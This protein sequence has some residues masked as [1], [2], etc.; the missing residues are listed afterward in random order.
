MS[1][2]T[3]DKPAGFDG[4]NKTESGLVEEE[5]EP[6]S[7]R[8]TLMSRYGKKATLIVVFLLITAYYIASMIITPDD[9][10]VRSVLYFIIAFKILFEFIPVSV[11]TKPVV[12]VLG[13]IP[14]PQIP[15]VIKLGVGIA[16]IILSVLLVT[17]LSPQTDHGDLT[18]RCQSLLG[19]CS[20][21]ILMFITSRN[22]KMINWQTVF[23]G[24]FFQLVLGLFVI[25]TTIGSDLFSWLSGRCA[26]FIGFAEQGTAFVFYDFPNQERLRNGVDRVGISFALMVLPGILFFASFIQILY[27]LG[28]MQWVIG[29]FARFF[30]WGMDTSGS[31]SVVAAAS[32][33]VGMGESALLVKP[34]LVDMTRSELHQVMTS[35]FST[36]AGS[37]M[38][39]FINMKV[40]PR[41]LITSCVMSIP[42]SL[43]LSKLRYPETEESLT[44]GEV[45]IPEKEEREANVLH[46][47]A[48]GAAQGVTLCLLIAGT[49]LAII[50]LVSMVD[51]VLGWLGEYLGF[52]NGSVLTLELIVGYLFWPF[53]WLIGIPKDE[54]MKV[55]RLM[56]VKMF[57]N[58]FAAF[59]KLIDL[60]NA[61]ALSQRAQI[62]ATYSLCG[63]ANFASIGI[64]VGC[65]GAMAPTR[66]RDLSKM[67]MSSMLTG[68]MCTFISATIAGLLI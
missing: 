15:R 41:A 45:I 39:A 14:I 24:I 63:F 59:G 66:K 33:F 43:A 58:E 1:K 65:L 7:L 35:G 5:S 40:D 56:A 38:M 49:L 53:A 48:N 16:L 37:V 8:P 2:V 25:K 51:G 55:G 19:L 23:T 31:E 26:A 10:L 34:F 20:F 50:A 29:K 27:Y 30:K 61:N 4:L 68:T 60:K 9:A 36:I 46:A 64:Q 28:A 62:L 67:A 21:L 52:K 47:A 44:K 42:C 6:S 32:P 3:T 54:C 18:N 13:S 17:F 12:S 11:I 22:R 57:A